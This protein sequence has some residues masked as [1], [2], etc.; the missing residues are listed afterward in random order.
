M[1]ESLWANEALWALVNTL[2]RL[3][4]ILSTMRIFPYPAFGSAESWARFNSAL[5]IISI[6]Y[7][8]SILLELFLICRPLAAVWDPN[9]NGSCGNELL[10]YVILESCGLVLDLVLVVVPILQI[11]LLQMSSKRKRQVGSVFS[12]GGV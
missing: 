3:S 5:I 2:L 12:L 6:L 7:A 4:V 9:S 8:I 11:R 1:S 10:A